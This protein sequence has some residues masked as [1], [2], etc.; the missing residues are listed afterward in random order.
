MNDIFNNMPEVAVRAIK[1]K[2]NKYLQNTTNDNPLSLKEY[3]SKVELIGNLNIE[4]DTKLRKS[5]NL[6]SEITKLEE[7]IKELETYKSEINELEHEIASLKST[8]Y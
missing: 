2:Y 8:L 1:K 6:D 4:L 3:S 5:K 7:K